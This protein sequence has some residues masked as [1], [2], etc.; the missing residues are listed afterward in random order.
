MWI[1]THRVQFVVLM[2]HCTYTVNY[3]IAGIFR[4]FGVL[5]REN[6]SLSTA[7]IINGRVIVVSHHSLKFKSRKSDLQQFAENFHPRK[8][9][10]IYGKLAQPF[11]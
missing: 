8:I 3:S 1:H 9:P 6:F 4:G 11:L 2:D 7:V 5:T 10:A